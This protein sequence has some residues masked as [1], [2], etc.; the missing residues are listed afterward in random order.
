MDLL[1]VTEVC[2]HV[3]MLEKG[4]IVKDIKTATE[5]LK[6]LETFFGG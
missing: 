6:E 5:T 4:R 1:H 2:E 3:V